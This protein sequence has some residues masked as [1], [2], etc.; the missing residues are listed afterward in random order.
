M[1]ITLKNIKV[2]KRSILLTIIITISLITIG[3][4]SYSTVQVVKV[5]G[6]LYN[7]IVQ[8]KDIIADI[9]PPPEYIIESYLTLHQ[10]VLEADKTKIDELVEKCKR[11]ESEYDDRHNY[12]TNELEDN[13]T[14]RIFL[15][16]SYQPVMAFYKVQDELFIPAIKSGNLELAKELLANQLKV[17]YA[18]HRVAIDKVV[19][20]SIQNNTDVETEAKRII[21]SRTFLMVII[22]VSFSLLFVL[23]LMYNSKLIIIPLKELI[24][25]AKKISLGDYSTKVLVENKD[26]LG[27]LADSFNNMSEKIQKSNLELIQEQEKTEKKDKEAIRLSE[28]QKKYLKESIDKMLIVMEK[29]ST[30]DLTVSLPIQNH[31]EIGQ[32]FDGFNKSISRINNIIKSVMEAVHA[33]A[34]AGNQISSSSEEMA[35][36]A[37]Q[38]SSQTMEVVDAIEQMNKTITET[39]HHAASAAETA[40]NAVIIASE[41]GKVVG[42]T[43]A[44]IKQIAEVV[45]KSS[46]TVIE[47][48][49][50]SDKIGE[51]VEVIDDIAA[52]TNLLALNAAIEAARAGEQGR[53]F[54]VVADEVRKLAERTTKATKEI[55]LMVNQ[56]QTDTSSAVV[57]I[58]LGAVELENG[59]RLADKAEQSLNSIISESNEVVQIVSRLAVASE[60]QSNAAGLISKNIEGINSV[61]HESA[62]GIQQIAKASEDLSSLTIRLQKIVS[63][64]KVD[65]YRVEKLSLVH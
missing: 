57:S 39:S 20:L 5:N 40:K 9:L 26:E 49:K 21:E 32:L 60:E 24:S 46:D 61:T 30:G 45:K 44:G 1:K 42:D 17:N 56:I 35:A 43:I 8:G 59:K 27:T 34:S 15:R 14:A 25:S 23:L 6:E 18:Q 38:Q 48:G 53:G 63:E 41:G 50:N 16:D 31:D 4:Y 3:L 37:Q 12:W 7:K 10:I 65:D 51:I 28:E 29:F 62:Q 52:Q 64:F 33:T 13:S 54:A 58:K 2:S 55:A 11:L 19:K 36:G 47:L 22:L